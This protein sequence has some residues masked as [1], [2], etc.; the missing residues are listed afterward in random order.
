MPQAY[1]KEWTVMVYFAADNNL[2][3]NAKDNLEQMRQ[4]GSSDEVNVIAEIDYV[5]DAPTKRYYFEPGAT[6]DDCV[7]ND[8]LEDINTGDPK[9]LIDF[10]C[11]GFNE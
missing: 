3:P 11:W 6:L 9:A 4:V 10:I 7:V 5:G 2:E 8:N 1:E